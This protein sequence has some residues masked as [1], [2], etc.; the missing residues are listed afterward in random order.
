MNPLHKNK[1]MSVEYEVKQNLKSADMENVNSLLKFW[2]WE[3][4]LKIDP[5]TGVRFAPS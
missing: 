4:V 2:V 3:S 1:I 5:A